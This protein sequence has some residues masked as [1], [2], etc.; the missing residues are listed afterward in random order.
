MRLIARLHTPGRAALP[1]A[2]LALA[3]WWAAAALLAP[4]LRTLEEISGDWAWRFA[5]ERDRERRIL[6]VDIDEAS[7]E[8]LGPWPW[9]RRRMAELSDRLA[10]EGAALQIYDIVFAATT[11]DDV[12]LAERLEKNRAVVS[13]VFALES[14]TGAASGTPTAPLPWAACPA[15]LPQSLG[16]IANAPAFAALPAGHITPLIERD[17]AL[18]RQPA[19]ICHE[20]RA[21][22]AL[23]AAALGYAVPGAETSLQAGAG[24]LGPAWTLRGLLPGGG[25]I[26]LDAAGNVRIPWTLQPGAFIS[27]SAADVLAGRIPQGL[28]A[29]AWVVVGSTSLGLS[30]RV[31]TPFGG[32]GA[33]LMVHGQLLRAALDSRLVAEPR[34][35]GPLA[36]LAAIL[37]S[38]L[39]AALTGLRRRGLWLPVLAAA[40]LVVVLWAVKA[41]LLLRVGLW[42][43]WVG[44]ALYMALFALFLGIIEHARSR[45]ES[46]RLFRHLSSYLPVPV[47]ATLARQDPTDAI[48][49]VRCPITALYADIRNFSAYCESRPPEEAAAVLHAFFTMVTREVE[50]HG[51]IVESFHGDAV[52]AVWGVQSGSGQSG[53]PVP[54]QAL[55]AALDI[56]RESRGLLPGP[57][58]DDPAPLALGIGLETGQAT[59]GSFG[60]VRR[61]AHLA[62]GRTVTTALRLQEMTGELAHPILVGEGMAALIGPHRLESQGAFLLEGLKAP[63]HIYAYPLRDCVE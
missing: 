45:F 59:V 51:G 36:A 44:A 25:G 48:D 7:L 22:P 4:T 18:R 62:I 26:P 50:R 40:G 57:A 52:L 60:P 15:S 47:A 5:A 49:A 37:F 34:L 6:L 24:L 53:D 27:L 61:R 42:F 20:G 39:I 41:A 13:Q 3:C 1:A 23:F 28:L 17:G 30:D 38:G 35:G 21:Y 54:E 12:R 31:A 19:L 14:G 11:P 10:G 29:N 58:P 8:Q 55:A 33:G 46:D 63:C 9:P 43:E 2:L 56:L 16:H 32:N